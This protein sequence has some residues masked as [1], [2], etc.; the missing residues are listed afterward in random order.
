MGMSIYQWGYNA[1]TE[2]YNRDRMQMC[3]RY[4]EEFSGNWWGNTQEMVKMI[5]GIENHRT[6]W[7]DPMFAKCFSSTVR[8]DSFTQLVYQN[9]N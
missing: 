3:C 4:N 1:D 7:L 6:D 9:A 2:G 5:N 8:H